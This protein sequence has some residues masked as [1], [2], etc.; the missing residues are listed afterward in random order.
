[1]AAR[2]LL[3]VVGVVVMAACGRPNSDIAPERPLGTVCQGNSDCDSGI[4]SGGVCVSGECQEDSDCTG[5]NEFCH[6]ANASAPWATGTTGDCK[7]GC[8][9]DNDCSVMQDCIDIDDGPGGSRCYT[10]IDCNPA[11]NNAD[12][13]PAEV[14]DEQDRVCTAPGACTWANDCP[15]GWVCDLDDTCRDPDDEDLGGCVNQADCNGVDG[16]QGGAC[17]CSSGECKSRVCDDEDD[18]TAGN[19][20]ASSVCRPAIACPSGQDTCTA[21]SLVCEGGYCVNPD[22]CTT[23]G[24]CPTGY[25][26]NDNYDPPSCFPVGTNE[27]TQSSQCPV[28]EYCELFTGTCEPGCRTN[29]DCAGACGASP[30]CNCNV[31]HDCTSSA[32][33]TPGTSCTSDTA[34]GANQICTYTDALGAFACED[35]EFGAF[36]DCSKQCRTKCDLLT[37]MTE[38]TCPAGQTCGGSDILQSLLAMLMDS[39]SGAVCY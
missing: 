24:A 20:C 34:C 39:E 21:Y 23:A 38:N 37:S 16:C 10:N 31:E 17:T 22:P 29:A 2:K 14:C 26:C 5:D 35:S 8:G 19:Y 30:T 4:C 32:V 13:P 36:L 1:M 12:C 15:I 33:G 6:F 18:C 9:S 7:P 3:L 11:L 25:A 28:N 27:C